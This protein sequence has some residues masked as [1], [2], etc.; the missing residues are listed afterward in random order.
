MFTV[1]SYFYQLVKSNTKINSNQTK[2][3][4]YCK[5]ASSPNIFASIENT[6]SKKWVRVYLCRR[7]IKG[8]NFFQALNQ[9]LHIKLA[10]SR[11]YHALFELAPS[12]VEWKWFVDVFVLRKIHLWKSDG[13]ADTE[14]QTPKWHSNQLIHIT[15]KMENMYKMHNIHQKIIVIFC[16]FVCLLTQPLSK[17]IRTNFSR[18]VAITARKFF[19]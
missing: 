16:L 19:F 14:N 8:R 12:S 15:D 13:A 5:K 7:K 18:S 3:L 11:K 4:M 6:P 10:A 9:D 2:T 1:H 17:T